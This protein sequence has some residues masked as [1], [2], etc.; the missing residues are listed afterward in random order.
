ME[1]APT[2]SFP[3]VFG[4]HR[5]RRRTITLLKS[6]APP[7]R[8][9]TSAKLESPSSPQ[10]NCKS[11]AT[12]LHSPTHLASCCELFSLGK[13]H[14]LEAKR[15]N[16]VWQASAVVEFCGCSPRELCRCPR[17]GQSHT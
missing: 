6:H 16:E 12:R 3:A 15:H 13:M 11:L 14:P 5:P 1:R 10:C 8:S 4:I 9:A 17:Y 2:N 7:R